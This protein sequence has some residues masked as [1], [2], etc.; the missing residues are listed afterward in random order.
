MDMGHSTLFG[1]LMRIGELL[2]RY[3]HHRHMEHGPL[4]DPHRGQGRVMA[5][6][7]MRPGI[8]QKDLSYL[9]DIRPQSLGEL[10]AKLE[11]SG[12]IERAPSEE[13]RRVM[14]IRLTEEGEKAAERR[15]DSEDFFKS[16]GEEE[17]EVLRGFL[18]RVIADLERELEERRGSC[19]HRDAGCPHPHD[20]PPHE[21]DP[22]GHGSRGHGP[23]DRG[24]HGFGRRHGPGPGC[25][26]GGPH[27]RQR[28]SPHGREWDADDRFREDGEAEE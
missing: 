6:L 3:R 5:M 18:D 22:R 9:L 26:R 10:L 16:L 8:S 1:Q 14:D 25:E 2:Q 20:G 15:D 19:A 13:D 24:P 27:G 23:H 17:K 28:H 4:G 7:K 11:R 21:H 12:Y